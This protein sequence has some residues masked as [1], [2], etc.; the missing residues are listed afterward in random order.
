MVTG[1]GEADNAF[2][3]GRAIWSA[4]ACCRFQF[5]THLRNRNYASIQSA[6]KLAHSKSP[7][8]L[9]ADTALIYKHLKTAHDA[10]ALLRKEK[11]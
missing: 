9:T 3:N 11:S 7:E 5:R 6:R 2:S 1:S 4:A 10:A 8:T